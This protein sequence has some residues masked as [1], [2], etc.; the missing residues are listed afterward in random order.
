MFII[1][2]MMTESSKGFKIASIDLGN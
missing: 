2:N 1:W